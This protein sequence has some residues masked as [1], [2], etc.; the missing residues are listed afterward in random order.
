MASENKLGTS[1]DLIVLVCKTDFIFLVIAVLIRTSGKPL[2]IGIEEYW[3]DYFEGI[4]NIG[5]KTYD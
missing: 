1:S 3:K 2:L 4:L 5:Y